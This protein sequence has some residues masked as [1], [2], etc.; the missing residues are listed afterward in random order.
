MVYLGM[1]HNTS[2][3]YM[4]V[5]R[6]HCIA[7]HVRDIFGIHCHHFESSGLTCEWRSHTLEIC[8]QSTYSGCHPN[9]ENRIGHCI[10]K[11]NFV[12][13]VLRMFDAKV[14]SCRYQMSQWKNN[15]C[16][17]HKSVGEA[18]EIF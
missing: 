13:W 9:I 14:V 11:I 12:E 4:F 16:S 1:P 17:N 5:T 7:I 2:N 10:Q 18:Y 3:S 15:V 6:K 8:K